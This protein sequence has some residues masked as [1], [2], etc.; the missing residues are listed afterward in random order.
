VTPV[1]VTMS[2]V[3]T[4][5][6]AQPASHR[7]RLRSILYEGLHT[8]VGRL[9][10]FPG[11]ITPIASIWTGARQWVNFF[12]A[13]GLVPGTR[14]AMA[15]P[16]SPAFLMALVAAWWEGLTLIVLRD[17]EP[18]P[19]A[20]DA[21]IIIRPETTEGDPRVIAPNPDW[22]PPEKPIRP[23]P[24]PS[25]PT[26]T[27]P[28]SRLAPSPDVR[29]MLRTSGTSGR[30][31]WI[32]L[33]DENIASVLESHRP[34][35]Q[36][37][38]ARVL[39]A[40]P[41]HHAFGL[42]IDL[43]PAILDADTIVREPSAGRD[44]ASILDAIERWEITHLSMVPLQVCRLGASERGRSALKALGGG[45]VGGAKITQDISDVL[46][47]SNLRVGYGQ[48][49]ASPGIALGEP[50]DWND[51]IIGMPRGCELRV[52]PEGV[53]QFRG[54]N[55]CLGHWTEHGLE[56]WPDGW[57][58]TGDLVRA[59]RGQMVYLGR[60][61]DSFKLANGRLVVPGPIESRLAENVPDVIDA[62]VLSRDGETIDVVLVTRS[63]IARPLDLVARALGP[64]APRLGQVRVLTQHNV[65]RSAKGS[66][67]RAQLARFLGESGSDLT[68]A[69]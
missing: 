68:E 10:I 14:V 21:T 25:T 20:L 66:L 26:T 58:S 11:R 48:T 37:R 45:V 64:L 31:R 54:P 18:A 62:A 19:D 7:E 9:T 53:L 50:G 44:P 56:R 32:A 22:G 35:L 24:A 51:G 17:G 57:R 52:D 6:A 27:S 61:D 16:P 42:L 1:F 69:A 2:D 55:A 59:E 29:L 49:E 36:L 34:H 65:P 23:V 3:L 28:A 43:L 46:R 60:A 15:L 12:R 8:D 38:G 5:P 33:S 67:D 40:L 30:P 47:G 13:S 41:W 4:S 39:S 63:A